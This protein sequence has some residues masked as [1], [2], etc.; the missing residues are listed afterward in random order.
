MGMKKKKVALGL[1]VE[2]IVITCICFA[3]GLGVGTALSQ[4]VSDSMMS[5]ITQAAD[6]GSTSLTDRLNAEAGVAEQSADIDVSVSGITA[7]EIFGVSLLLASIAGIISVSRITKCEPIK[8]LM[9][10][11]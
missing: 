11:N 2:T 5:G 1:W 9:E 3:I 10:R 7:L 6:T 4:P 8:I